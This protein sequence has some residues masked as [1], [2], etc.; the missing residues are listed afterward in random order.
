[1]DLCGTKESICRTGFALAKQYGYTFVGA[2]PMAGAQFS[3]IKYSRSNLFNGAPMIIVPKNR[4]DIALLDRA[5]QAL[6]PAGFS[7]ISVTT[8]AEHDRIIAFTSQLAHLVSSAYI[9]SPTA[10]GH[11]GFSAGSYRDMTR[12]AWLNETMWGELFLENAD[13][14][15]H[16][17][18]TIL[19]SLTEYREALAAG[20]GAHLISLLRDGRLAKENTDG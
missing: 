18:D 15:L 2:H 10:A 19:A 17:L 11:N 14:L 8:P 1:M 20:D 6:A 16:E 9:K 5:R 7:K 12:V 3:G 4:D 13:N